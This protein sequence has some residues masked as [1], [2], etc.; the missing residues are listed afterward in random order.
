MSKKAKTKAYHLRAHVHTNGQLADS[1]NAIFNSLFRR[2]KP[3]SATKSIDAHSTYFSLVAIYVAVAVFGCSPRETITTSS[4]TESKISISPNAS[5]GKGREVDPES[6]QL[7]SSKKTASEAIHTK[8]TETVANAA[9]AAKPQADAEQQLSPT[10]ALVLR[11]EAKRLADELISRFP[12]NPDALEIKAR[13]LMLFGETEEAKNCW[14]A[15]IKVDAN[16]AYALHG[17]GKVAMLNS[18]FEKAIEYLRKSVP[19]QPSNA[20]PVHDLSAAYM[21]I[22]NLDESIDCLRAF[23]DNNPQSA[24][25]FLLLG[26]N[27]LAKERFEDA[28]AAFRTVLQIS[29]AQPRAENGLAT[30]L[31][32]QGK[33]DEAKQLLASQ[34]IRRK[35]NDKNRSPEEV[36]HDELKELS[37]RFGTVAEFYAANRDERTA[38]KVALR[39]LVLDPSNLQPKAL[40]VDLFQRQDRLKP[41]LELV[42]QLA[43]VEKENPKW[44]YT[45]GALLSIL[46]DTDAARLAYE[47]VV[48]LAPT[49]PAGYESLARLA[50]GTRKNL[51]SAILNAKKAVEVRGS[52][53]DHELLAQAYALNTDFSSALESLTE[54][55]RRDPANNHYS[56]AMKQLRKAM[57]TP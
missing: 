36:F 33:R 24:L 6:A 11:Q 48:R 18:E 54:A 20:D 8:T 23:A 43:A 29:P 28:A 52:A 44:P 53:T 42:D 45:R 25:T 9:V 22:G 51:K 2:I 47:D 35:A 7:Q 13:F 57:G 56:E 27:Y 10:D 16:Y 46:G 17:L 15:A 39:S 3:M 19:S 31:V 30:V 12:N 1:L 14:L 38:E 50:I 21:K 49:S 55:I 32:R 5:S 4:N 34:K 41:A 37:L 40:L 26:Q